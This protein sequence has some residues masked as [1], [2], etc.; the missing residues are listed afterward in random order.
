MQFNAGHRTS[1]PRRGTTGRRPAR[2][3]FWCP[4][5]APAEG[6]MRLS[7]EHTTRFE[8]DEPVCESAV[9]AR[10][11]PSDNAGSGQRCT[12]FR[13]AVQPATAIFGYTDY[14][15][16]SVHH[17]TVLP[18]HTSLQVVAT[19]VVETGVGRLPALDGD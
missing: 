14:Y 17:F 5:G 15:G 1:C 2:R 18:N 7:I 11:E 9:E 4:R 8:Y 3:G 13:L 19:S 16:N 6:R 10:L 12:Q